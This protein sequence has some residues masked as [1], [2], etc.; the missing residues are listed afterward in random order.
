M[1][2]GGRPHV[3]RAM[4]IGTYHSPSVAQSA[5]CPLCGETLQ[6]NTDPIGRTIEV[7]P[8]RVCPNAV[9]HAPTHD[10][11]LLPLERPKRQRKGKKGA[12]SPED[13]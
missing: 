1:A 13:E 12:H 6:F 2:S 7:C 8:S 11:D 3:L 10:V 9:G 4:G 5:A